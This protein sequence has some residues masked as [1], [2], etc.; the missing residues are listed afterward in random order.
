M[1]NEPRQQLK[2]LMNAFEFEKVF[3]DQFFVTL[4]SLLAVGA[5]DF[6]AIVDRV[7]TRV[8][9][10]SPRAFGEVNGNVRV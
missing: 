3:R 5:L 2:F 6:L 8:T 7:L 10:R 9:N 4:C 1:F